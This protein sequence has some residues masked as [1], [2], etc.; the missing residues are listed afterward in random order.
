M[1][2]EFSKEDAEQILYD[3]FC[4]GGLGELALSS[5]SV[6]WKSVP[7]ANNYASAKNRLIENGMKSICREDIYIEILKNGDEIIFTDYEGEESIVL[8]LD[9]ALN[10]LNEISEK[11]KLDLIKLLDEDDVSSDIWDYY[12]AI[13]FALYKEVIF[14]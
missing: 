3:T 14:G 11:D 1:K 12:N 7:N 2:I 6:D 4:N 8:T 5:V 9:I 13:Q 10:N